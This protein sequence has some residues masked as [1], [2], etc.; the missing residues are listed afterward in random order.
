MVQYEWQQIHLG[1]V[2]LQHL[3]SLGSVLDG[4]QE[5]WPI[6]CFCH[7]EHTHIELVATIFQYTKPGT[8]T[9]R[10][11]NC[12]EANEKEER[13]EEKFPPQSRRI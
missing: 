11:K 4:H 3:G 5:K 10:R 7:T 13:A 1:C 2:G 6:L 9:L 12:E 8:V